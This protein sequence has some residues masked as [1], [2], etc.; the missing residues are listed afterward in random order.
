MRKRRRFLLLLLLSVV[1]PKAWSDDVTDASIYR[2]VLFSMGDENSQ[3]WRIP[4]LTVANDG[5]LVA[6]ADARGTSLGDLPNTITLMSRRSTDNGVTWSD[7]VVVAQGNSSTGKT[8]GDAALITEQET[9]KIICMYVGDKGLWTATPSNRQ[10]VYYSESTDNGQTWS[11][12]I[13]ITDQVY[14]NHSSWYACFAGSGRGLQLKDGRLIYIL[15]VRP[16]STVG[17]TLQNWTLYSDDR[18][19]TWSISDNYA[20]SLGDEAKA[21][22]LEDGTILMSIRNPNKGYR[23]FSKSTDSGKS[24]GESYLNETLKEANCNGDIMRCEYNGESYLVHSLPNSST[25]REN[26][27]FFISAD[28][29]DTWTFAK[30]LVD[31]YSAYSSMVELSDGTIGV[32]VEEGKWDNNIEGEDGFTLVYYKFTKDWLFE[33]IN[34]GCL[35]NPI[36]PSRQ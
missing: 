36:L 30:Q 26:V 32:L 34:L 13:S 20:T 3:Y 2:H 29:G 7:P 33:N 24:W 28:E 22:E 5:S 1:T 14:A 31:G 4:A 6:V 17:G 18:G 10:G 15:A 23:R 35:G 12:P 9:G 25:T 11:D 8:Y 27:S 16:T 19:K 21:I